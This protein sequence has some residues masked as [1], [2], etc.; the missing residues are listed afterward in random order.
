MKCRVWPFPLSIIF[1][2][3]RTTGMLIVVLVPVV[4]TAQYTD[5]T[6]LRDLGGPQEFARRR[7]E[8][9]DQL[10]T[11]YVVLFARD[12]IPEATHYREDNDFYYFT[13]IADPGAIVLMDAV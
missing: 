11:G 8:L 1:G 9:A 2:V 5:R 10:K 6:A 3:I 13:G 12:V 7:A 4:V